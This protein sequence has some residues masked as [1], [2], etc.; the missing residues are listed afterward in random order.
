VAEIEKLSK[1]SS[2]LAERIGRNLDKLR[3]FMRWK[4]VEMA[5][6]TGISAAGLSN[7]I[8]G[9]RLPDVTYLLQVCNTEALKEK[10]LF[11]TVDALLSENFDPEI[12]AG[13]K[14]PE[15]V[16]MLQKEATEMAGVYFCY[17]FDQ[18][19]F[20]Y[21]RDFRDMRKLRYGVLTLFEDREA[22]TMRALATFYSSEGKTEAMETKKKLE[23]IF[24]SYT[25][26]KEREAKL[27]DYYDKWQTNADIYLGDVRLGIRHAFIHISAPSCSDHALIALYSTGNH[28][29]DGYCG[30]LGSVS[31]VA[32]GPGQMPTAQKIIISKYILGCSEAEIASHL[33]MEQSRLLPD[34][35]AAVLAKLCQKLYRGE[36]A[37]TNNLIED[38]K[39]AIIGNRLRQL[40]QNYV[41]KHVS[42][43]GS[44]SEEDNDKVCA[45]IRRYLK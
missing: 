44:V 43:V 23:D 4:Q 9:H 12:V 31:S 27:R 5:D 40:L 45:L 37:I 3:R 16:P 10:N 42:S 34:D 33:N 2:A 24:Q 17:F 15:T 30:G 39:I 36:D 14:L 20:S 29:D 26:S 13:G 1:D 11:L 32:Q 25:S 19:R 38:D 18:V 8:N 41:E 22:R 35:E 6:V 28:R 21:D 7:Y